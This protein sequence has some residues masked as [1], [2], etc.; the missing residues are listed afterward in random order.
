MD[1]WNAS[2]FD[3]AALATTLDNSGLSRGDL[4]REAVLCKN[5]RKFFFFIYK[6]A[7]PKHCTRKANNQGDNPMGW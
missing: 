1:I 6:L 2:G 3:L 4:R 5:E 7:I